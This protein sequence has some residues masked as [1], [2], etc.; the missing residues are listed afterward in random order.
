MNTMYAI[1]SARTREIGTLRALGFSR[2]SI[3]ISFVIESALLALVGGLLGC[4]LALPIN[5]C[6]APP[7]AP[8]SADRVR[9]PGGPAV[10]CHRGRGGGA[11]GPGRRVAAG[12]PRRTHADHGGAARGVEER[13]N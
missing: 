13:P 4:L 5:G 12:V 10:A 6:R 1:V 7:A 8:T 11:D 9:V 3:L 2:T